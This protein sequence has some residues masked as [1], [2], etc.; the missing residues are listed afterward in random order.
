[1]THRVVSKSELAPPPKLET[2]TA[3]TFITG[4]KEQDSEVSPI[5]LQLKHLSSEVKEEHHPHKY[6]NFPSRD[7]RKTIANKELSKIAASMVPEKHISM[8]FPS[9][10]S[11]ITTEEAKS[12]RHDALAR[13]DLES[14]DSIPPIQIEYARCTVKE[15]KDHQEFMDKITQRQLKRKEDK[16]AK[17]RDRTK[18]TMKEYIDDYFMRQLGY[19]L[20]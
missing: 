13:S 7:R 15:K 14:T 16:K 19:S 5:P 4:I 6:Y 2:K 11:E 9:I 18:V 1:M 8:P 20:F 17:S 10:V 12:D 3:N